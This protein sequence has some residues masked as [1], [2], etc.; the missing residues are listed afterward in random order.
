MKNETNILSEAEAKALIRDVNQGRT[1]IR[2]DAVDVTYLLE[3]E[4]QGEPVSGLLHAA[5]MLLMHGTVKTWEELGLPASAKP[6][7]FDDNLSWISAMEVHASEEGSQ[8]DRGS[9]S[10]AY[11]LAFF[12]KRSDG[13]FPL[14]QFLTGIAGEPFNAFSFLKSARISAI[15]F[16]EMLSRRLPGPGWTHRRLRSYL[17]MKEDDPLIGT[18]VKPKT[19]LTPEAFAHSVLEAAQAGVK[20][21]KA[22]ENMHLTR[23][24]LSVYVREVASL[25]HENGFD[26]SRTEEAQ[27]RRFL[28]APHITTDCD[29]LA[30]YAE[31]AV[32]AGA[33]ALMFSPY[34]AGGFLMLSSIAAQFDVPVYAHTA[35]MNIFTGFPSWGFDPSVMYYLAASFGASFMQ[36]TTVGSYLRPRDHEKPAILSCLRRHGLEGEDGM[37]IAIAGGL[38]APNAGVNLQQLGGKGRMLLAGTSI[39][40]HPGG[41]TAGVEAFIVAVRAFREE[42]ITA[43]E[44]LKVYAEKQ[45]PSGKPLLAVL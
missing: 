3:V 4:R 15:E 24:Q 35:G 8:T 2:G 17:C 36:V 16:P 38:T 43:P 34:Y 10:V 44:D 19:G 27:G 33:N 41:I 31:T 32:E 9:L 12:D 45:G 13:R 22:D 30:S 7:N 11:P 42:G 14:A 25:L 1:R 23:E 6:Q 26:L 21:T 37:T 18:I 5:K 40:E 28:F 29:Q 39:Y 20:F